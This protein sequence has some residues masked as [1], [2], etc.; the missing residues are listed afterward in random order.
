MSAFQTRG[1][2]IIHV[3]ITCGWPAQTIWHN[4]GAC[5][6]LLQTMRTHWPERLRR[7]FYLST[8]LLSWGK[9]C[10]GEPHRQFTDCSLR[11]EGETVCMENSSESLG[12]NYLK[13]AENTLFSMQNS[14][15]PDDAWRTGRKGEV[16]ERENSS[17]RR[18]HACKKEYIT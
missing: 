17:Q 11:A 3:D 4:W 16:V 7:W 15:F 5:A 12:Q 1:L 10:E 2:S 8:R 13:S 14:L 18:I 9:I 6:W